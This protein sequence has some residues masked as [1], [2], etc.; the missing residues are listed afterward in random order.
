[1]T[2]EEKLQ[3][4]PDAPGVY[5]MKDVTGHIIYIGKALSLWSRV[6]SYF[7]KG[8]KGEKTEI[9]VRQIADLETIVTHTELEAL[10]LESNLIKKHHPRYNII[11]RDDKNYPYLRFDIRSEYPRLEVVRRLKKD[12]ALYY[13]PYVPA[14][15]MWETLALIRRTFPLATCK[16]EFNRDRPER[17]CVQFQIGRCLAPCS[18][19]VD[20]AAYQDM[21]DQVRLFIEG[22]NHDLLDMLKQR[23]EEASERMEYERAAELRDRIGKIE[24]AFEKQ[25]IISP[26]FENQDV[27]GMA[28]AGNHSDIQVL[29]IRNGLLLGRKDFTLPDV[30]GMTSEDVLVDFLHQFYAKEMIVPAEVLLPQEVPDRSVF[31][32]WLSEKRGNRVEVLVPQRGR[33]RELVQM[34]SDNAAQS[35]REQLLSRK[36]KERVLLRL[37]EE[38]GL[39]NLPRR[40]EAFDISTIQGSESVASMV[41]FENNLPDKRQYK[42]FKIRSVQG[43]DDFASMA[44]VIGRRY[45]RAKNEGMLPDLI[46]IDGGKGQLNAALDVLKELG[47]I[48]TNPPPQGED[49][50]GGWL[51]ASSTPSP[52]NPPLEGDG[53]RKE[54]DVIGLAKARSGDEGRER[55]FERVFLPGVEEPIVLEPTNETTHLV[56]RVRD[57]AHRFA[58]TYHRKLREKR[59]VHSEL[60][61]IPG[62]GDV[63][64]KALLRHFGSVEKIKGATVEEMASIAGMT[65]KAAEEIVNYFQGTGDRVRGTG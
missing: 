58:I 44:E 1:M 19:E 42:R 5:I 31:E 28:S 11:L 17:P 30:H 59:A 49:G 54:P 52:P 35:L 57:E 16:K 4:L 29:F 48:I 56:A 23:M 41:S 50:G 12:K 27:I 6:R 22:K 2:L 24:G 40:I 21:V 60:D 37:Q 55:E 46:L 7:Q 62:I 43:Q 18:A 14:G 20:P 13:G 64:K 53:V 25:K 38:L 15:G 26:G 34:A 10:A 8:A 63:R 47:I 51:T 61:D 65:R 45:A 39:R 3:N 9:M 36:S 33:K 32:A